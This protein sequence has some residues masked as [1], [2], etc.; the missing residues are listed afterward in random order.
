VFRD[1]RAGKLVQIGFSLIKKII[2]IP[3]SYS[4]IESRFT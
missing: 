2:T 4:V 1:A 3:M